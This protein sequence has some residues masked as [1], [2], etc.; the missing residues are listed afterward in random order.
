MPFENG[1][2]VQQCNRATV[3]PCNSAS[4]QQCIAPR[5]GGGDEGMDVDGGAIMKRARD[6]SFGGGADR[7]QLGM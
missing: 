1:G 2:T 6:W 4:V 5:G 3:Q 7:S